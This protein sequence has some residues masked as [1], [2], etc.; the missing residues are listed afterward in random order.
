MPPAATKVVLRGANDQEF[1][2]VAN[3]GMTS[4]YRSDKTIP[5]VDVVQSFDIHTT[6]T[7]S[8]TG[9]TMTPSTGILQSAFKT[10]NR[11]DVVRMIV[12]N[13]IEKNM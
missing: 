6:T 12:E 10:S 3:P 4:K 13:G 1:F 7:G 8:E 2:V 11:D 9:E 5:L